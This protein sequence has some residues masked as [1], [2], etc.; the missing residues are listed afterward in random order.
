M[1]SENNLRRLLLKKDGTVGASIRITTE[2][3]SNTS[4]MSKSSV[5][6]NPKERNWSCLEDNREANSETGK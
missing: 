2:P 5:I 6:N 1:D 3:Y 4:R